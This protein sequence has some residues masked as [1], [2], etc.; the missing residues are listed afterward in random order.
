MRGKAVAVDDRSREI[1]DAQIV[2]TGMGTQD[3]ERRVDSEPVT[4]GENPLGLLDD[5]TTIQR[6]L[7]L[8]DAFLQYGAPLDQRCH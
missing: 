1:M 3:L 8:I 4:L 2:S 6:R 5:H 7:E